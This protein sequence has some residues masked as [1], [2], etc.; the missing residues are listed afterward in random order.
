LVWKGEV[1]AIEE[2]LHVIVGLGV[3][4]QGVNRETGKLWSGAD[5][6]GQVTHRCPK[7]PL[8]VTG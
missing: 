6:C 1:K 7:N 4:W 8:L 2:E 5:I 3:T